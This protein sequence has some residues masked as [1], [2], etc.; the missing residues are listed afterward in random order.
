MWPVLNFHCS[1]KLQLI[2]ARKDLLLY[3]KK[4]KGVEVWFSFKKKQTKKKTVLFGRAV[5]DYWLKTWLGLI[6]LKLLKKKKKDVIWLARSPQ[7]D[8]FLISCSLGGGDGF[9][10][11][12]SAVSAPQVDADQGPPLSSVTAAL[13]SQRLIQFWKVLICSEGL[14]IDFFFFF[15]LCAIITW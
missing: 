5:P 12:I 6:Y 15:L 14:T 1:P 2:L 3:R 10:I 9:H 11:G 4:Q 7:A 13:I 8:L